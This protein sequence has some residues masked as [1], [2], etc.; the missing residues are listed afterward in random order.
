L[1]EDFLARAPFPGFEQTLVNVVIYGGWA[2]VEDY[3]LWCICQGV[4]GEGICFQWAHDCIFLD[5]GT[6]RGLV[7]VGPSFEDITLGAGDGKRVARL[8]GADEL[9]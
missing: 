2:G 5:S 9:V 1:D 3:L 6:D 8:G 7:G 4:T